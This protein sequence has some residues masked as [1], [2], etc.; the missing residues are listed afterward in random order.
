MATQSDNQKND[1]VIAITLSKR[2]EDEL[3]EIIEQHRA[4]SVLGRWMRNVL[5][6]TT[7]GVLGLI[8]FWE[9]SKSFLTG[10]A[11]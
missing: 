7:G 5:F 11:K 4:L 10:L 1:E 8:A 9:Q 6:V 2:D 3:R